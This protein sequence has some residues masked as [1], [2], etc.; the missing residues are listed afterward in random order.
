MYIGF[1]VPILTNYWSKLLFPIQLWIK[2]STNLHLNHNW[3]IVRE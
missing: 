3:E 1:L 2:E